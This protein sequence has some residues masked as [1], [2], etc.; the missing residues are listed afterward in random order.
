MPTPQPA[1][2]DEDMMVDGN[3]MIYFPEEFSGCF[4]HGDNDGFRNDRQ[5]DCVHEARRGWYDKGVHVL[6]DDGLSIDDLAPSE[7]KRRIMAYCNFSLLSSTR[8]HAHSPH[9]HASMRDSIDVLMPMFRPCLLCGQRWRCR[10]QDV[11]N[12]VCNTDRIRRTHTTPYSVILQVMVQG[13][14][15]LCTGNAKGHVQHD[16]PKLLL[17]IPPPPPPVPPPSFSSAFASFSQAW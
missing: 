1:G 14:W 8:T 5:I 9:T 17:I 13:V 3:G 11:G 12:R 10:G 15:G 7:I 2:G 4:D 16:T 6:D